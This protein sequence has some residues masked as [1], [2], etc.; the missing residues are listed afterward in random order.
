MSVVRFRPGSPLN[1]GMYRTHTLQIVPV[2][3]LTLWDR[4]DSPEPVLCET[5]NQN[6]A[7]RIP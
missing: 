1:L 2:T 4:T 5:L 6:T 3:W 7:Y